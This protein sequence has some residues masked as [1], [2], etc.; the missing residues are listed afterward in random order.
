M[1]LGYAASSVLFGVLFVAPF[2]IRCATAA[3]AVG[4]F[5]SAYVMTRPFGASVADWVGVAPARGGVGVDTGPVSLV[6]L[7]ATWPWWPG[8][9][10][11]LGAQTTRRWWS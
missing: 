3:G 2:A 7:L 6:A 10:S 5:W 4:V 8:S 1:G 11:P 9:R